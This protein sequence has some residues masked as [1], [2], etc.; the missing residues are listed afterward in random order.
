MKLQKYRFHLLKLSSENEEVFQQEQ[1]L[2]TKLE[3][4]VKERIAGKNIDN[5]AI[6]GP[7]QENNIAI[8]VEIYN[9]EIY[10]GLIEQGELYFT[11][12]NI[13]NIFDKITEE[14]IDTLDDNVR[15]AV[16]RHL[17]HKPKL[18]LDTQLENIWTPVLAIIKKIQQVEKEISSYN[19]KSQEMTNI[20]SY[21]EEYIDYLINLY[22]NND[23]VTL[24][25]E[26]LK[27]PEFFK[28]LPRVLEQDL[29]SIKETK[30]Q[31]ED[32]GR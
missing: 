3:K 7:H 14:Y 13:K 2:F 9:N 20:N 17:E 18:A 26:S 15:A 10:F 21:K 31:E 12:P 28:I 30:E 1:S 23:L 5:L 29:K 11:E 16:K 27:E 19:D 24:D 6:I 32:M 22:E 4:M 25:I 8:S